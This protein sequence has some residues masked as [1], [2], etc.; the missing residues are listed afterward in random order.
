[1]T[2]PTFSSFRRR[3]SWDPYNVE[4][5]KALGRG[6]ETAIE[7]V[8]LAVPVRKPRKGEFFRVHPDPDMSITTK[9]YRSDDG[10]NFLV[11]PAVADVFGRQIVRVT[12][13]CCVTRFADPFLW[14]VRV[15]D[16]GE[17]DNS[18]WETARL[19]AIKA[20][21]SWVRIEANQAAKNYS[22]ALA[23]GDLPE[24][25]WPSMSLPE[26]IELAFK[27]ATIKDRD[28]LLV[29]SFLGEV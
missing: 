16:E 4:A 17:R 9:L 12:L 2:T 27:N 8:L 11:N 14:P 29:Q 22:L 28:H 26:I 25:C 10:E 3:K 15:P 21:E 13:Y 24:P 5:L 20:I 19:A 1:M 6:E 18:Y 23:R 7:K